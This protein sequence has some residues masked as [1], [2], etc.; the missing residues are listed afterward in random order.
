MGGQG[1]A[2]PTR[3]LDRLLRPGSDSRRDRW[4]DLAWLSGL[5]LLLIG[6]GLGLRDPWPADEPRF[7]LIA[8][9]MIASGDWLIP[10]VGGDLYPDKPPFYFW[11]MAAA[12]QVSGS[13]QVGFLLVSLLAGLGTLWLVYD[14]LSRARGREVA[15]AGALVLL[16]T[17]QFVWQARQAQIDATL[18]F[19]TTLSLYG[20]LRHTLLGP[21]PGWYLLGWA[22]AGL[23]V[24]TKGVGFLPLLLL[25]PLAVLTMRGWPTA[26]RAGWLALAG[27]I[28]MLAAIA[29]WFV[30]ML[31][32][33]SAG[34]ELL[35]YRNEILFKQ[36]V[37]RYAN[38]WHHHEPFWYYLVNVVPVLWLPLIGLLPWL[39]PRWRRAL[40]N[41]DTLVAALLAWVVI[42]IVF[43]SVSSG[44]RGVYVLPALPAFAM[45]A[46]PSLPGLLR[47]RG[48]RWLAFGLAATLTAVLV[49][50]AV[51]T[52]IGSE[53][54]DELLAPYDVDPVPIFLFM[55]AVCSVAL[56]VF[57]VRNG[58][59]AYG[60]VLACI[61]C[62]V[63]WLINPRIDSER[64]GSDFM[65]ALAEA[66]RGVQELGFVGAK[67]QYLLQYQ[68][69]SVNFG[70][71]RWREK[72][73]EAAD[74]AAW[75][76][77]RPGRALMMDGDSR[78]ACFGG[79]E[80]VE[81]GRA[82]RQHWFLVTGQPDEDCLDAGDAT[83]ARR[84]HSAGGALN[85]AG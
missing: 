5:A 30:P 71:A 12:M 10:R 1:A 41:R 2:G 42:V 23:G 21:A 67:E 18:C 32:A 14:L 82:N 70:H 78:E 85:T 60:A 68:G 25:L 46:A 24:I 79:A 55:A 77:T 8:R 61:L 53:R 9:D 28:A 40:G 69:S 81:L 43:F 17:F 64:S 11:L 39:L 49:A 54:L 31:I 13:L 19:F 66:S 4:I 80:A 34:G 75:L 3:L 26:A 7:A 83:R 51:M 62:S 74:A 63:G 59:L 22:A 36:T 16:I 44:K 45:A 33:T 27:P 38:A 58:W 20:L 15:L 47:A 6:A 57:R 76:V 56:A 48:P 52:G 72:E 73:Q 84:Y 29:L 37:T 50:A 35:D 65:R